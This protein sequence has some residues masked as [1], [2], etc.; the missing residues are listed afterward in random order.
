MVGGLFL[1]LVLDPTIIERRPRMFG[2][3][4]L[5]LNRTDCTGSSDH[6]IGSRRDNTMEVQRRCGAGRVESGRGGGRH[7]TSQSRQSLLMTSPDTQR[8]EAQGARDSDPD[9][10]SDSGHLRTGL[11][12]RIACAHTTTSQR[13]PIASVVFPPSTSLHMRVAYRP[14]APSRRGAN[15]C[16]W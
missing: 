3:G 15:C 2:D 16:V 13:A 6:G 9:S 10:D 11:M 8:G 12:R 4:I 14:Q 1:S 7:G 5:R